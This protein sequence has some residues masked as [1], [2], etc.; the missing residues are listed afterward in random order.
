MYKTGAKMYKRVCE[1]N[2]RQWLSWP[3]IEN[4]NFL[5]G[6]YVK[7]VTVLFIFYGR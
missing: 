2:S 3:G 1:V 6:V 5:K 4:W 7:K